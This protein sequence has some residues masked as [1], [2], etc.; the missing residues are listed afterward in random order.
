[1]VLTQGDAKKIAKK[2]SAEIVSK[3][4][5]DV[6][7]IRTGNGVVLGQY[8][9]RRGSKNSGHDYIPGQIGVTMR[10]AQDL[11]NCP[12]SKEDYFKEMRNRGCI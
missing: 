2:L 3:R 6:A 1:M 5:H 12:M 10:Q 8:G 4:G 9:I 7:I 11:V